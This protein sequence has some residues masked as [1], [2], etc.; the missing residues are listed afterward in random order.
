MFWLGENHPAALAPSKRPRTTLSPTMA[1][2]DGEP[3]L[4]WGTPGG[5]QQDQRVT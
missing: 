3:H 2:R 1:L 5:D 4:P